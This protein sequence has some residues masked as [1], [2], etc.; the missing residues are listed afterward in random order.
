MN[1]VDLRR[2]T[3]A[4]YLDANAHEWLSAFDATEAIETFEE[5]VIASITPSAFI[6]NAEADMENWPT[7][8][9]G[10]SARK[11][12]ASSNRPSTI[13][14]NAI[15]HLISAVVEEIHERAQTAHGRIR[16]KA[17]LLRLEGAD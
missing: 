16:L 3:I 15:G 6:I 2:H 9:F 11:W 8:W 13:V 7:C 4:A 12:I 10:Q 5:E 1:F 14:D 17:E